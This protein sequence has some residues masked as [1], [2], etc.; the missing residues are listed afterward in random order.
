MPGWFF[1]LFCFYISGPWIWK[2]GFYTC[3]AYAVVL[4]FTNI[5]NFEI[6]QRVLFCFPG[7]C[8]YCLSRLSRLIAHSFLPIVFVLNSFEQIWSFACLHGYAPHVVRRWP[9][10]AWVWGNGCCEPYVSTGCWAH[11]SVRPA[12]LLAAEPILLSCVVYDQ[13]LHCWC[14]RLR[15]CNCLNIHALL[16]TLLIHFKLGHFRFLELE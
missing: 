5:L 8:E 4:S 2:I 12:R 14:V 9:Q 10:S 1:F 16:V 3:Q 15:I 13:R 7:C 6:W 11:L